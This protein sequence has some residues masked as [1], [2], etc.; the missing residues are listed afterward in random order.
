M[1]LSP[2]Q[3]A[4]FKKHRPQLSFQHY[5]C[6]K[7]FN[8]Y[9]PLKL[10]DVSNNNLNKKIYKIESQIACSRR[11]P[12]CI[13]TQNFNSSHT[14]YCGMREVPYLVENILS[15]QVTKAFSNPDTS[16][17]LCKALHI[18][19][20]INLIRKSYITNKIFNFDTKALQ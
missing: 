6:C 17:F 1:Y 9:S 2:T 18:D 7:K 11:K 19:I 14:I 20:L 5:S 4:K 12:S 15:R 8:D 3:A 13:D 10:T 16:S